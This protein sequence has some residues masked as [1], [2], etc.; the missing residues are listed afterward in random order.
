MNNNSQPSGVS[1][2]MRERAYN[3][4]LFVEGEFVTEIG[5]VEYD[6]DGDDKD[7]IS[8][9]LAQAPSDIAN[10]KRYRVPDN[11]KL[12]ND[13]TNEVYDGVLRYSKYL[14]LCDYGYQN[15]IWEEILHLLNAGSEP[16]LVVSAVVDGEILVDLQQELKSCTKEVNKIEMYSAPD[17]LL[18]YSD[19]SSFHLNRLI[20]DDFFTP[21]KL[22][23]NNK[24]Y[25]SALKLL[26]SSIDSFA[27]LE[28]GDEPQIFARWLRSYM[29]YQ[30]INVMP[31]EIW[32]LR[33]AIIH[34]SSYD[35]RK[36]SNGKVSRLII[37]ISQHSED[38]SNLTYDGKFLNL[39]TFYR[40]V[41]YA[42]EKWLTTV[43][44]EKR[45]EQ[46]FERYDKIVSENRL[47][48]ML[49]E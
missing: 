7:K 3:L 32:E 4:Y 37:Q 26:L 2:P 41:A 38:V 25:I 22:L 45:F 40:L 20:D 33:N 8:F 10:S 39:Y 9:L 24:H 36:V 34:M 13:D 23:L 16:L 11:C 31:E 28:Y 1:P 5:A 44:E 49:V 17:Y 6:L 43:F 35:S 27:Y 19:G 42:V 18:Q 47:H 21:I 15:I 48:V 29:D 46:F 12:I 14:E 30:K